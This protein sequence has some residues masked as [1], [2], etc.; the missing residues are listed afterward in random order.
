MPRNQQT[1]SSDSKKKVIELYRLALTSGIPL[2]A[3]QLKI[4]H[5][6]ERASSVA[7]QERKDKQQRRRQELPLRRRLFFTA[8][9]L[10]CIMM[11]LGFVGTA[12]WPLFSYYL[13]TPNDLTS[14]T[15]LAPVPHAEVLD[16]MP[17]ILVQAKENTGND[18]GSNESGGAYVAP[19]I[20][21]DDLDY[22]NL[23]NWFP[24]LTL[25]TV[26][27]EKTV[28]YTIEIPKVKITNAHV[29]VG[30]ANLDKNLIQYPGT[31][32]PGDPGDA[33]I[34]GHSILR[35]FYNPSEKN[36]NRYLSIFSTI[37]TL[38]K[39]DKIFVT[40]GNVKYTYAVVEKRVVHPEDTYILEQ[41]YDSREIKLV[42]CVPE[43]TTK[44]RGVVIA[45]LVKE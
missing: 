31:A 30:G 16:V 20:L 5:L 26:E 12:I 15:L 41:Q 10:V 3:V 8:L 27:S 32:L 23:S 11:G 39:G 24:N 34:F 22:T 40:V 38:T 7:E 13:F 42:T 28:E 35:Q 19:T 1:V 44:D 6:N 9:P 43:G 18:D 45:Q 4:A 21:N 37:M 2:E 36:S 33:V 25:P 14:S 17:R 29:H